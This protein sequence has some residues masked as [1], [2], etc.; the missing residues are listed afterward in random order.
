MQDALITYEQPLNEYMRVCLRLEHLFKRVRANIGGDTEEECRAALEAMLE[1]LNVMDRPDLKTRLTKA[2]SQH[3]EALSQLEEKPLVD[4]QKLQAILQ[5]IDSL[6]D[7][8]YQVPDKIGHSLRSNTFLNT[9]RQHMA[10]PGGTCPFSTPAYYLWL[11]RDAEERAEN[12]RDWFAAFKEISYG[13]SLLLKL[14]R[15]S[16]PA[17]LLVATKGFYQEALDPKLAYHLVRITVPV[18]AQVYPEISAGKHRLVVRFLSLNVNDRGVQRVDD[19]EFK[20]TCC[21]PLASFT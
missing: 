19:V 17:K 21:L 1:A 8:L 4:P 13:V 11:H 15:G 5:E 14:T 16:T 20:L 18:S 7:R 2:L 9:I 6:V 10:N 12:L 3:A